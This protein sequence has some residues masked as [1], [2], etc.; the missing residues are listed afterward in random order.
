MKKTLIIVII[1]V[2]GIAALYVTYTFGYRQGDKANNVNIV[3]T[4][5]EKSCTTS[6]DCVNQGVVC[7]KAGDQPTCMEISLATGQKYPEPKCV[8][9]NPNKEY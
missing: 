7:S 8:C 1:V 6:Q 5:A 2:I 9:L 4:Q 3:G